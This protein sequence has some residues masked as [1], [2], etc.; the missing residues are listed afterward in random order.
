MNL[1]PENDKDI[2]PSRENP[3]DN[4]GLSCQPPSVTTKAV[5]ERASNIPHQD[6]ASQRH[7]LSLRKSYSF[8]SD[9]TKKEESTRFKRSASDVLPR[10]L[11]NKRKFNTSNGEF[12][13]N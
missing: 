3:P 4:G 10:L 7:E 1:P 6:R 13:S 9:P 2:T 11:E 8:P 12:Y 5:Y